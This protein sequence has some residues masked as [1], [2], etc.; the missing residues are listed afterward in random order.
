MR[1]LSKP[2]DVKCSLRRSV[3]HLDHVVFAG[4]FAPV[5]INNIH[6]LISTR[7]NR[8]VEKI[9][10]NVGGTNM[11]STFHVFEKNRIPLELGTPKL[12]HFYFGRMQSNRYNLFEFKVH[13]PKFILKW[14]LI[15]Y[16]Q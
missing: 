15:C 13:R 12:C 3:L 2:P 16:T 6:K 11:Y 7:G 14:S 10:K 4:I 8:C 1:Q 9:T 5:K